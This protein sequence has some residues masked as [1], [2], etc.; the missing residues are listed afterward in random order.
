MS[1]SKFLMTAA[2][3]SIV[4]ATTAIHAE[5]PQGAPESVEAPGAESGW[6]DSDVGTTPSGAAP[7][8]QAAT[9]PAALEPGELPTAAE[10]TPGNA[11]VAPEPSIV[12]GLVP[13]ESGLEDLTSSV[14]SPLEPP[15]LDASAPPP[16]R[17]RPEGLQLSLLDL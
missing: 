10:P 4:F 9:E 14:E 17:L 8:S 16:T 6:G 7:E 5:A 12:P 11:D 3:L 15:S 2:A 1:P 13:S